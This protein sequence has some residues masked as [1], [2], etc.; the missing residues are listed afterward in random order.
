[1][2]FKSLLIRAPDFEARRTGM[3]MDSVIWRFILANLTYLP[4]FFK[5]SDTDDKCEYTVKKVHE[6]SVSSQ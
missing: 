4:N 6:F 3:L 1:M 2:L 5:T